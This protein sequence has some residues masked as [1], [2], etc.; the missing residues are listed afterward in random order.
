MQQL[1]EQHFNSSMSLPITSALTPNIYFAWLRKLQQGE[2]ELL[3]MFR[4]EAYITY[5]NYCNYRLLMEF[6][7]QEIFRI[8]R[9]KNHMLRRIHNLQR[10]EA[11]C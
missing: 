8:K 9:H 7:S 6:N 3:T 4:R 2:P 10:S 1:R 11:L 5:L